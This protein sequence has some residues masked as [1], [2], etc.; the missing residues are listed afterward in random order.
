LLF[1]TQGKLTYISKPSGLSGFTFLVS[2]REPNELLP[3]TGKNTY[4]ISVM[5]AVGHWVHTNG[6]AQLSLSG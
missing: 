6:T 3:K 5:T 2:G 1:E 4:W